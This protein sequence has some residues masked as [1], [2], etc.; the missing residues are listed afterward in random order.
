MSK[1]TPERVEIGC[2]GHFI[3]AS[4]CHFSRHTQIGKY[5]VSTIGDYRPGKGEAVEIGADRYYETM[6]FAT[7]G[8]PKG[9]GC[10]PVVDYS[11]SVDFDGYQTREE[12]QAGHEAIVAEWMAKVAG[13]NMRQ[14][15]CR[16]ETDE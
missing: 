7:E 10:V 14:G 13:A 15:Q 1:H 2:R 9:C 12:A 16:E 8:E 11:A 4:D 6:V 3:G 5:R